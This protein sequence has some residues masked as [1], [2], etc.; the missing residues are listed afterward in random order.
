[1]KT[2]M[3]R[4]AYAEGHG[5]FHSTEETVISTIINL[6]AVHIT[7][8]YRTNFDSFKILLKNQ[9]ETKSQVATNIEQAS[10]C[11]DRQAPSSL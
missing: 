10:K 2:V 3:T 8:I 9:G 5:S 1:M 4:D 6:K 7:F 11:I